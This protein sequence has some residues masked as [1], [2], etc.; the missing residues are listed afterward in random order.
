MYCVPWEFLCY[1][2]QSKKSTK[3]YISKQRAQT[4]NNHWDYLNDTKY[5][6][7]HNRNYFSIARWN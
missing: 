2:Q 7:I 1:K 5:V 6:S 4:G 3:I